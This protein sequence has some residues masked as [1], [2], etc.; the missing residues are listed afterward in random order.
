MVLVTFVVFSQIPPDFKNGIIVG[1]DTSNPTGY[2]M[3]QMYFNS[4]DSLTYKYNGVNWKTFDVIQ[5]LDEGNGIG[6]RYAT[7]DLASFA[8]IGANALDL[9]T[10]S[11]A[12]TDYGVAS[13]GGFSFGTDNKLPTTSGGGLGNFGLHIALGFDNTVRGYYG[14]LAWGLSNTIDDGYNAF[15]LG[16]QN[17]V[18][19]TPTVG[20]GGAIGNFNN[21]TNYW[22]INIGNGLINKWKGSVAVGMGNEDTAEGV[23]DADRPIFIIGNGNLSDN[24]VSYGNVLNRSD[25][26]R[27]LANGEVQIGNQ[28]K[29]G[30]GNVVN[31]RQTDTLTSN[32]FPNTFQVDKVVNSNNSNLSYF[33]STIADIEGSANTG[34]V[35]GLNNSLDVNGTGM[36][37]FTIGFANELRL[38]DGGNNNNT[39]VYGQNNLLNVT[40]SATQT[41]NFLVGNINQITVNADNYTATQLY[42]NSIDINLTSGTTNNL[43]AL[44]IDV[45]QDAVNGTI[46]DGAYLQFD[47]GIDIPSATTNG[48]LVIESLVDLPSE[49]AGTF[50][51]KALITDTFTFATLPTG[52]IGMTATITDAGAVTY[53]GVASGGGANIAL[54]FYDGTQWIYH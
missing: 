52:V 27:V 7:S 43:Q 33:F 25:A 46:T 36:P 54:V 51:A 14:N 12:D 2:K 26:M 8:P 32:Y 11:G 45:D 40:T 38:Q 30:L 19:F 10:I 47:T 29:S 50:Q 20:Q 23:T 28:A 9:T 5:A 42:G 48:I 13:S 16:Y 49:M 53:R 17:T 35:R 39:G 4:V 44:R 3:G 21:N 22:N 24:T 15:A 6:Y 31:V 1:N 41:T 34:V 37:T 18:D